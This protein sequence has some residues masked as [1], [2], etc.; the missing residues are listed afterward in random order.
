[1]LLLKFIRTKIQNRPRFLCR[2]RDRLLKTLAAL[3]YLI[4]LLFTPAK[5]FP[6]ASQTPDAT[7][8]VAAA[9][10]ASLMHNLG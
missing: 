5:A 10:I 9:V 2:V 7:G 3:G 6:I 4:R 8:A 1:M